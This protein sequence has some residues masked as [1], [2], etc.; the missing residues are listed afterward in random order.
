MRPCK[1]TWGRIDEMS[2]SDGSGLGLLA[3]VPAPVH[4]PGH[5]Q[6]GGIPLR[7]LRPGVLRARHPEANRPCT[8]P[9]RLRV[10]PFTGPADARRR[11]ARSSGACDRRT[12]LDRVRRA[13]THRA[14]AAGARGAAHR[15]RSLP[16]TMG[17]G[18]ADGGTDAA[19]CDHQVGHEHARRVFS[20]A[21]A[22]VRDRRARRRQLP[23]RP[24]RRDVRARGCR[25]SRPSDDRSLVRDL[26]ECGHAA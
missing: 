1:A 19:P 10:H 4:H 6:L 24:L 11:G 17:D 9:A 23:A 25:R 22:V 2:R 14:V 18:R 15:R 13:A 16:D 7:R 26:A 5:G 20:P 12:T 21:P 3:V 8:L